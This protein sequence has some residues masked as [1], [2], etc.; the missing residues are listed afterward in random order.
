MKELLNDIRGYIFQFNLGVISKDRY[1]SILIDLQKRACNLALSSED[2]LNFTR[3]ISDLGFL[4]FL[5]NDGENDNNF[6]ILLMEYCGYKHRDKRNLITEKSIED[7]I[8]NHFSRIK[9]FGKYEL[10]KR[11]FV[12]KSGRIDILAKCTETLRPVIMEVKKG[13]VSAHRQLLDYAGDFDNPILINLSQFECKKQKD[14]VI[15]Y[16]LDDLLNG[17]FNK[18]QV[19]ALLEQDKQVSLPL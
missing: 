1:D 5:M 12:S 17:L 8:V 15:Y 14:G 2:P 11:Q 9:L 3:I 18:S 6:S 19:I 4:S 10:V 13:S 7:V 16:C